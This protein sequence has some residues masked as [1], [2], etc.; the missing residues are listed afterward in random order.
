MKKI[1]TKNVLKQKKRQRGSFVDDVGASLQGY[2]ILLYLR[3]E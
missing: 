2:N 1:S 3:G